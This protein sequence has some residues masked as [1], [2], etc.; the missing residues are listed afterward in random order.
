MI[1]SKCE[2][3]SANG[4]VEKGKFVCDPCR[5][6]KRLEKA[7]VITFW[8]IGGRAY[9]SHGEIRLVKATYKITAKYY[10]RQECDPGWP[11]DHQVSKESSW[12]RT[13]G[14]RSPE[15]AVAARLFSL[16]GTVESKRKDYEKADKTLE[17]FEA[18][19]KT[20]NYDTSVITKPEENIV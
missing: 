14:W 16:R 17:V 6:A 8:S 19:A 18:W 15:E 9:E 13:P 5:K 3:E 12:R 2:K 4:K 20:N 11:F 10:I 1:C 7:E